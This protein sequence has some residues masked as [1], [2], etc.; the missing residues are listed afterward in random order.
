VAGSC[1]LEQD[2]TVSGQCFSSHGASVDT[3]PGGFCEAGAHAQACCLADAGT[4]YFQLAQGMG[5]GQALTDTIC[6]DSFRQTMIDIARFIA[7]V[8]FVELSEAPANPNAIV[9]Q[10]TREGQTTPVFIP[11]LA[12]TGNCATDTGWQL[13]GDRRINFCGGA[14]PGPGDVVSVRALG[15]RGAGTPDDPCKLA[16]P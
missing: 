11:P 13:Q 6:S 15:D 16:T 3:G 7:R 8:D 9:V 2:A 14:A 4:R 5:T 12:S 1:I 10:I